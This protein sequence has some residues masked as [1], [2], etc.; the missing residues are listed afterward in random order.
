MNEYCK[1]DRESRKAASSGVAPPPVPSPLPTTVK[2]ASIEKKD[3]KEATI[4]VHNHIH[5]R[6]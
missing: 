1:A 3:Y 5:I 6:Q 4:Q 2:A